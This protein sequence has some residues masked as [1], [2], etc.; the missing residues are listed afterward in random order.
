M[1]SNEAAHALEQAFVD[2]ENRVPGHVQISNAV[3][4]EKSAG[5][6]YRD[7]V[8]MQGRRQEVS[9]GGPRTRLSLRWK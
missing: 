3:E 2:R 9:P 4:A 5:H 8:G 6:E 1:Q 7:V